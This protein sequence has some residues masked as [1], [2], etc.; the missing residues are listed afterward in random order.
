VNKILTHLLTDP[1]SQVHE[2]VVT[3]IF[4]CF[5]HFSKYFPDLERPVVSDPEVVCASTDGDKT[6]VL[7]SLGLQ[8][9]AT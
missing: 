8:P 6:V 5:E 4:Q 3:E 7:G 1:V 2:E 9:P